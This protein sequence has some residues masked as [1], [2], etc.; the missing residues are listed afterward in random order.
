MVALEV[1]D[2]KKTAKVRYMTQAL[3]YST[4]VHRSTGG[5]NSITTMLKMLLATPRQ[6]MSVKNAKHDSILNEL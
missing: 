4:F 3:G 5:K 2:K 1:K 6:C